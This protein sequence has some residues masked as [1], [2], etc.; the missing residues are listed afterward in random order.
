MPENNI[1]KLGEILATMKVPMNRSGEVV[2]LFKIAIL[3]AFGNTHLPFLYDVLGKEKF[4]EV[5]DIFQGTELVPCPGCG[6]SIEWPCR[7][8]LAEILRDLVIYF[9][10]K[11][12]RLG[13]RAGV[14]RDLADDFGLGPGQVRYVN[15]R[16]TAKVR[17]HH[18][19]KQI[20]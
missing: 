16:M 19:F 7:D 17:E 18:S 4:L 6:E 3:E 14:V 13:S 2:D 20:I 9:R 15:K 10:I 1:D 8:K 11:A 5:L 12:A